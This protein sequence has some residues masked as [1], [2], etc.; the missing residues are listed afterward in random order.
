MA[1]LMRG[2]C[3]ECGREYALTDAG[4]IRAHLPQRSLRKLIPGQC[5]G[6]HQPPKNGRCW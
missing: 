1:K 6:A 2:H 3:A 5:K 4:T